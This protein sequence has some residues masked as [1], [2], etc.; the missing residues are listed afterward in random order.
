ME[1]RRKAVVVSAMKKQT[2]RPLIKV[3]GSMLFGRDLMI[4]NPGTPT[5]PPSTEYYPG[6]P[7][8]EGKS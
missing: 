7:S 3:I 8:G 6:A 1:D 5:S 4:K 2:L